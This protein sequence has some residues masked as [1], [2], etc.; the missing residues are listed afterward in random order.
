MD[1]AI[2]EEQRQIL[3]T[4]DRLIDRH[5]PPEAVRQHDRDHAPPYH[6]LPALG[7][8]GLLAMPF[9]AENGGLAAPWET[10]VLVQERLG[11]RALMAASLFNRAIGFGGMSLVVYG[12]EAQRDRYLPEI[13]AGRAF[14]ALALTESSAGSDAASIVTRARRRGNGWTITG[15]KTWIS[16]AAAAAAMVVACRTGPSDSGAEGVSMFLVPPGT[17]GVQ[18]TPL[19]KVGNNCLP[20]FDIGFDEVAVPGDALMGEENHGF[21]HLMATLHYARAGMAASVTGAAQAAVDIALSHACERQQFGRPIGGFQVIQHRLVDMQMR[22]DQ[23]RLLAWHLG[24]LIG[25][26]RSCRREASQ[27][28]IAATET[29][30]FVTDHGMQILASVGYAAESDMQRLWRDAR[31]Y[32]FGEGSNEIQRNIIARELGL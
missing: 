32:S 8:A 14:F 31:L 26:G 23:A 3:D 2:S 21:R 6:V 17:P 25:E 15:R 9:P 30:Q 12:S 18:M 24:W 10:V 27:A 7:E 5:L 19:D 4:V 13:M 1:F 16:D 20:C 11:Y 22:V 29:L 28:K